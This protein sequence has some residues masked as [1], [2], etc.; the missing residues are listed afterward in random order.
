MYN[1]R[2]PISFYDS[3]LDFGDTMKNF[4][5]MLAQYSK[6]VTKTARICGTIRKLKGKKTI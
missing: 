3:E 5:K 2:L 1:S 4:L 6:I